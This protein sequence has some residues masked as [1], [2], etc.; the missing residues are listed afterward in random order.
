MKAMRIDWAKEVD[1]VKGVGEVK[2]VDEA[3]VVLH[4]NRP[5]LF[6]DRQCLQC[7]LSNQ[8]LPKPD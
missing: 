8:G 3:R 2:E 1:V 7:Q 5:C 4:E 6:C